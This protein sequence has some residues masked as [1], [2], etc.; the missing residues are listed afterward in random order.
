MSTETNTPG[1]REYLEVTLHMQGG[2]Q[3]LFAADEFKARRSQTGEGGYVNL[4][5]TST[6]WDDL[7]RLT[8]V[9]LPQLTAITT[10]QIREAVSV[11]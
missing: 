8:S 4:E 2:G 6:E 7:P 1:Q 9:D 11:A 5:W 3:V 10:R